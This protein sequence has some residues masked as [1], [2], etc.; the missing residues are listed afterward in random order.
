MT[1]PAWLSDLADAV[2]EQIA[3]IELLSPVGCH[4]CE[5]DGR[6]EVAIFASTTE[7]VGGRRDGR[8]VQSKFRLNVLQL[9]AMFDDVLRCDWQN[10]PVDRD[11]EL[12][13]HLSIEGS[14]QG[15]DVWLRILSEAPRRFPA[16]R[17]A[18]V[19]DNAIIDTW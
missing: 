18:R 8:N 12:G 2:V 13:A 7:V 1:V 14:H 4:F 5:A 10:L 3:P 17:Q 11:D 16:G 19:H 15:H 6:W 9:L